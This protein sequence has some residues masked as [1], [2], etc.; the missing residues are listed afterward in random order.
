MEEWLLLDR[1]ALHARNVSVGN[2]K[3]AAAIEA[4]LANSGLTLVNRATVSAGITADSFALDRLPKRAIA[5]ANMLIENVAQLGIQVFYDFEGIGKDTESGSRGDE[6]P[7]AELL[8]RRL[9][10]LRVRSLS[11]T[12]QPEFGLLARLRNL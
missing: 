7:P 12:V 8:A 11:V 3:L 9:R 4:D 6:N 1:I 10:P 5:L 2:I